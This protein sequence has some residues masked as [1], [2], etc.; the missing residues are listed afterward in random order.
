MSHLKFKVTEFRFLNNDN[1]R[2][3][4]PIKIEVKFSCDKNLQEDLHWNV[5]YVPDSQNDKHDQIL[6]DAEVGPIL[7][8][9]SEF[10][11]EASAPI[12]P[13]IPLKNR[14]GK[15]VLIVSCLYKGEEWCRDGFFIN[16]EYKI[17]LILHEDENEDVTMENV[18]SPPVGSFTTNVSLMPEK[19][20]LSLIKRTID[21]TRHTRCKM[22][23]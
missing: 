11:I 10:Q 22:I 3:N 16:H 2:F 14:L 6:F 13:L 4:D 5:I 12:F 20:N 8:G 1:A 9:V 17:P 7:E 18:S 23:M 21:P 19:V 15:S